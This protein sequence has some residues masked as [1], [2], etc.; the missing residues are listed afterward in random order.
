MS[1][2]LDP[3]EFPIDDPKTLTNFSKKE[4]TV[5]IFQYESAGMQNT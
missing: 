3:D 2:K 5:G 4:K 1:V